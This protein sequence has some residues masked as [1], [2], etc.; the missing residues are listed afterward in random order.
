V[1]ARRLAL[2]LEAE[3]DQLRAL[4]L[5]REVDG[6]AA[7][8]ALHAADDLE[9]VAR[10]LP[11]RGEEVVGERAGARPGRHAG[12]VGAAALAE[13]RPP[14]ER[15]RAD[16]ALAAER[17]HRGAELPVH[18]ERVVQAAVGVAPL[19]PERERDQ[20][21]A[22]ALAREVGDDARRAADDAE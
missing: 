9:V 18:G 8:C 15:R 4:D 7:L 5:T 6:P 3:R 21:L 17:R 14:D 11:H 13:A 12:D 16:V 22:V 20:L 10:R 2:R 1:L 19:A